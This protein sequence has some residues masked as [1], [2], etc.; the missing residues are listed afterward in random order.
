[1]EKLA[2]WQ[3]DDLLYRK[4]GWSKKP[5]ASTFSFLVGGGACCPLCVRPRGATPRAGS[6]DCR[7]S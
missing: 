5:A 7:R 6:G 3:R 1:M 4:K 2:F